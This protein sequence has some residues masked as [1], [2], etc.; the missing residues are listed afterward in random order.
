[1]VFSSV[2]LLAKLVH[3][4]RLLEIQPAQQFLNVFGEDVALQIDA[5]AGAVSA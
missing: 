1:M 4:Q 3:G 2:A 5:R